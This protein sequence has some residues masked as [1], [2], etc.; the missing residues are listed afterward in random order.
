MLR[1]ATSS[2]AAG[3]SLPIIVAVTTVAVESV[4][5]TQERQSIVVAAGMLT[6][7]CL[8]VLALGLHRPDDVTE[9]E[10][11]AGQPSVG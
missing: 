1:S 11:G 10:A 5:M 6:V 9:D 4:Q 3:S 8:P 2:G 7:L